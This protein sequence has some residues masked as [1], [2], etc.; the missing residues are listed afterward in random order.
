[1]AALGWASQLDFLGSAPEKEVDLV[2]VEEDWA[3]E[4][5]RATAVDS[6]DH[7]ALVVDTVV[8]AEVEEVAIVVP[9]DMAEVEE[10]A[11]VDPVD[12]AEVVTVVQVVAVLPVAVAAVV[13]KAIVMPLP[14]LVL[15]LQPLL[16]SEAMANEMR[17][18]INRLFF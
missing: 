12:M 4:Q 9:V 11:T 13:T 14:L 1:M 17:F 15:K 6:A 8:M 3:P 18:V 7:L 2:A 10:V 5:V 16:V